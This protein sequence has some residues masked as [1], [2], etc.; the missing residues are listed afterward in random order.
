MAWERTE[1]QIEEFK[2]TRKLSAF[3]QS[4]WRKSPKEMSDLTFR[5]Y[6]RICKQHPDYA[7]CPVPVG[8]DRYRW[9][10]LACSISTIDGGRHP[11]PTLD[12][13][14]LKIYKAWEA[15]LADEFD[16]YRTQK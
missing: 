5:V 11:G 16:R 6:K 4:I 7:S 3:R 12:K 14:L 1:E 15:E 2:N 13:L 8:I 9:K 10:Q